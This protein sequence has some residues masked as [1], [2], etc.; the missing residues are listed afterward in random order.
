MLVGIDQAKLGNKTLV[1]ICATI[2]STFSS[3]F[4]DSK[5]F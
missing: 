5:V 3:V 2:N 4:S 1:S